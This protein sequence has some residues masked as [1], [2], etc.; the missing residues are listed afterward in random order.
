MEQHWFSHVDKHAARARD[1]RTGII[2]VESAVKIHLSPV[3]ADHEHEFLR[4]PPSR[5]TDRMAGPRAAP[6]GRHVR[7]QHGE[8]LI[9]E[10]KR[11]KILLAAGQ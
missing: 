8:G 7:Q 6:I 10:V 4:C 5:P 11:T 3:A 9:L 1:R 2:V